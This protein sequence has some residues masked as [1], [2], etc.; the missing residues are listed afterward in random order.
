MCSCAFTRIEGSCRYV[1]ARSFELYCNYGDTT[2][3]A[4]QGFVIIP[5]GN[6]KST[7]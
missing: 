4:K 1:A 5:P 6:R 7:A 3:G 2:A